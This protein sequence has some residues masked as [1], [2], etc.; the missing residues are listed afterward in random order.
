MSVGSHLQIRLDEYDSRIRTFIPAYEQMLA[1]AAGALN[2]LQTTSTPHLVDLGTG[3]GALAAC[4]LR[5]V[6]GASVTAVDEDGEILAMA[7]ERLAQLGAVASFLQCSFL[8]AA[9]PS[10]DAIVASLA[11]HH[12]RTADR[13]RQ[14]YRDCHAALGTGGLLISA[15]C[16]PSADEPLAALER[17]AWREHLRITYSDEETDRYF[18]AWAH[19]DVYVP[20]S[21]E[22][23]LLRDAGFEPEVVWRQGPF[24]VVAARRK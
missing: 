18:A 14:L 21:Q 13:K 6:P 9:L 20:L 17:A 3:T 2:A 23:A 5:T 15:D 7:R 22:L 12:V 19:E 4:C 8:D 16:C 24:A 11:L 1:A 10:C